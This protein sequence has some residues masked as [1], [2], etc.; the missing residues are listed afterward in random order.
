M[1]KMRTKKGHEWETP[2]TI[3]EFQA[4]GASLDELC[5]WAGKYIDHMMFVRSSGAIKRGRP[6]VAEAIPRNRRAVTTSAKAKIAISKMSPE[7]KAAVLAALQG[8]V[9][10]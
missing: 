7:V 9:K 6:F 4:A 2:E 8:E 5:Y 3:E 1:R 10:E